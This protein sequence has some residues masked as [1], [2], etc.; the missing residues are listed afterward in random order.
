M[1]GR[2]YRGLPAGSR[3]SQVTKGAPK[4]DNRSAKGN[5][6]FT[7]QLVEDAAENAT[8]L[9]HDRAAKARTNSRE[10]ANVLGYVN[11]KVALPREAVINQI[12]RSGRTSYRSS[13]LLPQKRMMSEKT[14][15]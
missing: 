2:I 10:R 11:V 9:A 14:S 13:R 6:Q 12:S 3:R 5:E 15:S 4:V 8:T 7:I 1:G